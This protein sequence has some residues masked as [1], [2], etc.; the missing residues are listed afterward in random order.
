MYKRVFDLFF[1]LFALLFLSWIFILIAIAIKVT[2]KWPVFY[3]AQRTGM[4]C[5]VFTMYKF[6]TMEVQICKK[7]SII[8]SAQDSRVSSLGKILRATKL[9]ELPQLFNVVLGDMSIVG[10]RPEDP[11]IVELYFSSNDLKTLNVRPG[12]ASPGSLYNYSHG[13]EIIGNQDAEISY[14]KKLLPIKLALEQV[15]VERSSMMYDLRIIMRTIIMIMKIALGIR[16]DTEPEEMDR[17]RELM[18]CSGI[19]IE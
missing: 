4:H 10:P 17:A 13:D 3:Y 2:S 6:R 14:V 9:D 5:K 12:L 11:K 19:S 16:I 7:Q 18:E 8:T 1:A 15:Y